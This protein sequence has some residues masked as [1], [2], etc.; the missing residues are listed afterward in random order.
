MMPILTRRWAIFLVASI[1]FVLSQFYRASIAVITPDLIRDL[2]I[3]TRGLSLISAAFFYGYAFT[4]IPIGIYLDSIGPRITM[5]LLSL[6]GVVGSLVFACGNSLGTLVLGRTLLGIGMAASLIGTF[7]LITLWFGPLRFATI[8]AIVV[9]VGTAGTIMATTPLVFMVQL[10]GWRMTFVSFAGLN[11]VLSVLFFLIVKDRPAIPIEGNTDGRIDSR[12]CLANLRALI[13]GR[14]YWIISLGTFCRYGI[15]AAVQSLWAGPFL[16]GVLARSPVAAGNL[17]FLMSMG[18]I[19]GGPCWGCISDTIF[20]NRKIV[21]IIG[22][23]GMAAILGILAILTPGTGS[24]TLSVLFF[25]FGVFSGSGQI[26]YTHIKELVPI[27]RAGTAM[28]GINFFTMFGVAFFLQGLG[29][30]MHHLY[31]DASLGAA[32]FTGAFLFCIVCLL[33]TAVGYMFTKETIGKK[34]G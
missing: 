11:L 31:P 12:E 24:W 14:D 1:M 33:L 8:S 10:I 7:K 19:V 25:S 21:V 15:F 13:K 29:N 20:R 3:D 17:L 22:I 16:M 6:S 2:A 18:V 27:E 23:T 34:R 28:S 5:T 4:Q 32:A 9:S 30:L 26:M